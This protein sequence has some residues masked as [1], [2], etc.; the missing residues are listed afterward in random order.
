MILAVPADSPHK[1]VAEFVAWARSRGDK[2]ELRLHRR[3]RFHP[4]RYAFHGLAGAASSTSR[5]CRRPPL[6]TAFAGGRVRMAFVTGLDG[7]A[8]VQAGK[9]RYLAVASP[10]RTPVL[11]DLPAIAE[12]VP[13]FQA[14]GWFGVLAQ[15][16]ACPTPSH[17]K[18]SAP[19]PPRCAAPKVSKF[20][21]DRNVGHGA[22]RRKSWAARSQ[23]GDRPVG[24]LV[25]KFSITVWCVPND[26]PAH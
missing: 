21:T 11:P 15:T 19:S 17:R 3:R 14:V 8:M 4:R 10:K 6:L 25:K 20:V 1:S 24:P 26:D 12:A 9:V 22:A 7:A 5:L 16:G 13:G 2:G 18:L 23:G